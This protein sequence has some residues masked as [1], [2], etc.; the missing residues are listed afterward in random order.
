MDP[1]TRAGL[2]GKYPENHYRRLLAIA[3]KV[4]EL[5]S[6]AYELNAGVSDL[7]LEENCAAIDIGA[8]EIEKAVVNKLARRR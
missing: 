7:D 5:A 3:L 6:E 8:D 4:R 1:L 2:Y